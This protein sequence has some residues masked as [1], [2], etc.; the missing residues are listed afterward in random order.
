MAKEAITFEGKPCRTCKGTTRYLKT[1]QCIQ[2]R[3]TARKAWREKNVEHRA[4]YDQSYYAENRKKLDHIAMLRRYQMTQ[5]EY[6]EMHAASQGHCAICSQHKERLCIDHC[7]ATGKVRGLLCY[8]CNTGLGL[9]RDN[10]DYL[11]S[12]IEYLRSSRLI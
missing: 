10:V 5:E 9:M 8:N 7:H 12:A 6:D 4:S 3:A 2:C 1:N 11:A